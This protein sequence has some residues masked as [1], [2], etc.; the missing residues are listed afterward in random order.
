MA[1]YSQTRILCRPLSCLPIPL[2][3][4]PP[5]LLSEDI[6]YGSEWIT[7]LFHRIDGHNIVTHVGSPDDTAGRHREP[8]NVRP[9]LCIRVSNLLEMSPSSPTN[10]RWL[11]N[12]TIRTINWSQSPSYRRLNELVLV[13]RHQHRIREESKCAIISHKL[14]SSIVQP[15]LKRHFQSLNAFVW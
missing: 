8:C 10:C 4:Y 9:L 5:P 2:N 15:L 1:S 6:Y 12:R 14:H 3:H 13:S 7:E 11:F